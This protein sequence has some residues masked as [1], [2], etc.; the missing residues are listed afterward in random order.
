MTVTSTVWSG[1]STTNESGEISTIEA[2]LLSDSP[3]EHVAPTGSGPI[4]AGVPAT[5]GGP[6]STVT[7]AGS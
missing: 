7:S 6:A 2:P 3:T 4:D 1:C 5:P